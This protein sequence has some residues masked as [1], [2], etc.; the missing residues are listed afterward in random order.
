MP[1]ASQGTALPVPQ[2][3][4]PNL[5]ILLPFRG[6]PRQLPPPQPSGYMPS[7]H[8]TQKRGNICHP[9]PCS[10]HGHRLGLQGCAHFVARGRARTATT[11]MR[12]S[13]DG[14]TKAMGVKA[15]RT[16]GERGAEDDAT[17]QQWQRWGCSAARHAAL[18]LS[19]AAT[20]R[21]RPRCPDCQL[22]AHAAVRGKKVQYRGPRC[23]CGRGMARVRWGS[24]PAGA[25]S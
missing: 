11:W 18:I 14:R 15:A 12:L 13:K 16:S 20:G 19:D 8:A 21:S 22:G 5:S 17:P 7:T 10:W 24:G 9:Q 6:P 3:C 4:L 23:S 25:K 2:C 1:L